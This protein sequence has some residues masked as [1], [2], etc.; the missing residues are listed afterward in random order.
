MA[1]LRK[2]NDDQ[3]ATIRAAFTGGAT[4]K[5]IA[6]DFGISIITA[7]KVKNYQGVYGP[8]PEE[9]AYQP[10]LNAVGEIIG[11]NQVEPTTNEENS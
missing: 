1:R 8:S 2:L 11:L 9:L 4:G 3:V 10:V 6:Q 7:Y 5:K